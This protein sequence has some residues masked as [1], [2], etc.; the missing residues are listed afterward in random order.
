MPINELYTGDYISFHESLEHTF[1][2]KRKRETVTYNIGQSQIVSGRIVGTTKTGQLKLFPCYFSKGRDDRKQKRTVRR[3]PAPL[4]TPY[5]CLEVKPGEQKEVVAFGPD[6][7]HP[8]KTEKFDMRKAFA[9]TPANPKFGRNSIGFGKVND[10]SNA[11]NDE[12]K[13]AIHDDTAREL[14]HAVSE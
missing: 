11:F 6:S 10:F 5:A 13:R 9:N 7:T 4:F 1:Y 14:K 12:H 8:Q 3:K 2:D